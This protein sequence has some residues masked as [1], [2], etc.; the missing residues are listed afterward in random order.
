MTTFLEP[1]NNYEL[2]FTFLRW[3]GLYGDDSIFLVRENST[4]YE[5]LFTPGYPERI[6]WFEFDLESMLSQ[7][8]NWEELG[9]ETV[10][11][12]TDVVF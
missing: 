2:G 8:N 4:G 10:D 1:G 12:L 7:F 6:K 9:Y 3:N 11:D 5:G